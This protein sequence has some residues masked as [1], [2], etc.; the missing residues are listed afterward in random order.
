[1]ALRLFFI[2]VLVYLGYSIPCKINLEDLLGL[3]VIPWLEFDEEEVEVDEEDEEEEPE[4]GPVD[5]TFMT[6]E[7][8]RDYWSDRIKEAEE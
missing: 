5:I 3:P 4:F 2:R 7:E 1:M 6:G 8:L